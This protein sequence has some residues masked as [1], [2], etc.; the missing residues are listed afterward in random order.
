MKSAQKKIPIKLKTGRPPKQFLDRAYQFKICLYLALYKDTFQIIDLIKDEFGI[1]FSNANIDK[2]Y[3]YGKKW[4][5]IIRYLRTRYLKNISRI[6]IANKHYRLS[7]LQESLREALTW[8]TKSINQWG[9]IQE[10]KIGIIPQILEQARIEVEGNK[11]LIDQ[12]QHKHITIIWQESDGNGKF[13]NKN[14]AP[15]QSM[16]GMEGPSKV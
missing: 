13:R 1:E 10:K 4:Q 9:T 5:P 16:E 7:A 12:S 8:H 14:T 15:L 3:R 2:N 6:P 11:P